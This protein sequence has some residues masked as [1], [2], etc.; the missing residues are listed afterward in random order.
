MK[1]SKKDD[2]PSGE[3]FE[4]YDRDLLCDPGTYPATVL[5]CKDYESSNGNEC[6]EV[7]VGVD[8][9]EGGVLCRYY[10][11]KG[12]SSLTN[13]LKAFGF[14]LDKLDD[15]FDVDAESFAGKTCKVQVTVE[16]DAS[17]KYPTRMK[18]QRL[19]PATAAGPVAKKPAAK[20]TKVAAAKPVD[21]KSEDVPF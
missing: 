17:G 1:V 14:D 19:Y 5:E 15:E 21:L 7:A 12:N 2:L 18:I 4:G 3:Q 10:A 6:L 9:P 8:A 11:V 13:W 16:E 20:R